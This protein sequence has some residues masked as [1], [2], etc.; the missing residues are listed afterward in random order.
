MIYARILLLMMITLGCSSPMGPNEI[1]NAD[2][3][4]IVAGEALYTVT[5]GGK[6]FRIHF[7]AAATK[8]YGD[9][10]HLIIHFYL[11]DK[12]S[13]NIIEEMLIT[14]GPLDD[15]QPWQAFASGVAGTQSDWYTDEQALEMMWRMSWEILYEDK[16]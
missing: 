14:M 1:E 16:P 5:P 12:A 6:P 8:M 15:T 4:F 2:P 10:G 13:G 11:V 9:G 7:T 3:E